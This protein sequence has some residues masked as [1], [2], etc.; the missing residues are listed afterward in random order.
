MSDLPK[1]SDVEVYSLLEV[2]PVKVSCDDAAEFFCM[3]RCFGFHLGMN[4]VATLSGCLPDGTVRTVSLY[5][6]Q[7]QRGGRRTNSGAIKVY[8]KDGLSVRLEFHEPVLQVYGNQ[9]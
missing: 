6:D 1:L 9:K 2:F 8:D 3:A 5:R 4:E 7:L